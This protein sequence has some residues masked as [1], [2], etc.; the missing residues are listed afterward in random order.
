MSI[1]RGM[2]L[3][4]P[5]EIDPPDRATRTGGTGDAMDATMIADED[6]SDEFH[7]SLLEA[8]S[9]P[10]W[11]PILLRLAG[12]GLPPKIIGL[13]PAEFNCSRTGKSF[14]WIQIFR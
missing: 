3:V 8:L 13:A 11:W 10:F 5:V 14:S 1:S 4:L 7:D 6:D 2:V 9:L 12:L